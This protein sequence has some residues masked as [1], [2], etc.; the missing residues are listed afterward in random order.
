ME[1]LGIALSDYQDFGGGV[2]QASFAEVDMLM[3]AMS[4]GQITGRDTTGLTTASGAPLK[5]ESLESTLKILTNQEKDITVWKSIPKKM[6]TNTVEE[7]NQLISYGLDGGAFTNEGELP[8]SQDSVYTRRAAYIKFM[9]VTREVTHPMQLVNTMVGNMI[10]RET[11][12]GMQYLLRQIEKAIPFGNSNIVSQ[13]FDGIFRSHF[14][15]FGGTLDAYQDSEVVIDLRG[16]V[17]REKDIEAAAEGINRNYGFADKLV[18]PPTVFSNFAKNFYAEKRFMANGLQISQGEVGQRINKVWTQFGPVDLLDSKFWRSEPARLISAAATSTKAPNAPTADGVAPTAAV[19]DTLNRFGA[20]FDGDYFYGVSAKNRY[21]ESSVTALGAT[22][23]VAAT[24]SVDLKFA[25]GG[26]SY[27]ATGYVI[28]RSKLG[29]VA[30]YGSIAACPLYPIFEVSTAERTA[31]YDGGAAGLVRDRNRFLP[32]TEKAFMVEWNEEI[33]GMKQLAPPMK[34]DLAV[35]SPSTRFMILCYLT[36]IAYAPK[37]Q[38]VFINI[39]DD[40]TV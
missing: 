13:Q 4:A 16:K 35:L 33:L 18:A 6:A 34:M 26:G 14:V 30:K 11:I 8:E 1:N 21:G 28:Y 10:Q 15:G 29:D 27:P 2:G 38:V 36:Y 25:D 7:Y 17:L 22:T 23:A 19:S 37:K 39:G 40:F 12:N 3:K 31:G 24:E 20:A 32:G 9:G 5:V